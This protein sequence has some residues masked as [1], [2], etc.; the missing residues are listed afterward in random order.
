[1]DNINRHVRKVLDFEKTCT[2]QDKEEYLLRLWAF[3]SGMTSEFVSLPPLPVLHVLEVTIM[4]LSAFS[5][6]PVH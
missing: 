4:S 5:I 1:M 6:H 2:K 3:E